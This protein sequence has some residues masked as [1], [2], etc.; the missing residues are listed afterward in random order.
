MAQYWTVLIDGYCP[1]N[2]TPPPI[3][4]RQLHNYKCETP[5][6]SFP[7]V[8]RV[9]LINKM[10]VLIN[11]IIWIKVFNLRFMNEKS[12]RFLKNKINLWEK[13]ALTL[14]S[15]LYCTAAPTTKQTPLYI[16]PK[17]P[18]VSFSFSPSE[19]KTQHNTPSPPSFSFNFSSY[20]L[21]LYTYI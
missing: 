9:V 10:M 21:I 7:T 3:L 18:H 12:F 16:S 4:R 11:L 8:Y 15:S 19:R 6:L 1:P 13:K 14:V 2:E 20:L 5:N 17:P